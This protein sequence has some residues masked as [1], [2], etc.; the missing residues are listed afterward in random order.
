MIQT[1]QLGCVNIENEHLKELFEL[2]CSF[3]NVVCLIRLV[4][5]RLCLITHVKD[6]F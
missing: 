4:R 5:V 6:F 1:K 2:Y 3:R